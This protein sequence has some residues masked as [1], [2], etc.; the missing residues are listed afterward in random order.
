MVAPLKNSTDPF[1]FGA[2][3]TLTTD[4]SSTGWSIEDNGCLRF[5]NSATICNKPHSTRFGNSVFL[6][7]GRADAAVPGTRPF[8]AQSRP[9]ESETR[10]AAAWRFANHRHAETNRQRATLRRAAQVFLP[11]T[12]TISMRL[13]TP[14]RPRIL[15]R[16]SVLI[17]CAASAPNDL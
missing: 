14:Q 1:G 2:L 16:R 7:R 11:P 4:S 15:R 13:I 12:P 8:P 9:G 10:R 3:D 5:P 17:F 6:G